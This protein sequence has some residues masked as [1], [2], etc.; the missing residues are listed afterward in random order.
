MEKT[1][2]TIFLGGVTGEESLSRLMGLHSDFQR[3]PGVSDAARIQP[4]S[5]V[6]IHGA[7]IAEI[8]AAPRREYDFT[9]S[10]VE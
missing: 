4:Q 10:F 7:L 3:S 8:Y 2:K 9:A 6:S 5:K 1:S